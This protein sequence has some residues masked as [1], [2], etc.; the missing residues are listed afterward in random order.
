MRILRRCADKLKRLF[1]SQLLLWYRP[2]QSSMITSSLFW[3]KYMRV[4]RGW[5]SSHRLLRAY[6]TQKEEVLSTQQFLSCRCVWPMLILSHTLLS[7]ELFQLPSSTLKWI[8]SS[9]RK[10]FTSRRT[11]SINCHIKTKNVLINWSTVWTSTP[12]WCASR[13]YSSIA[14]WLFLARRYLSSSTL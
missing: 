4:L 11:S 6:L 7:W 10:S 13:P 1:M 2:K 3:W 14:L 5:N 12:S 8:Y 9:W